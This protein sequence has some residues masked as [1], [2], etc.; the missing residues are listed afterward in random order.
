LQGGYPPLRVIGDPCRLPAH[1][2]RC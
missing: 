1:E 2:A